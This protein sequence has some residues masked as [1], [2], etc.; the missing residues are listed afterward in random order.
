MIKYVEKYNTTVYYMLGILCFGLFTLQR[1]SVFSF[2]IGQAVPLLLL[3]VVISIGCFFKEWTGFWYG[4]LCGIAVDTV[5]SGT[6]VFNTLALMLIGLA[7]GL[8]FHYIL[9]RNIKAFAI[10]GTALTFLYYIMRWVFLVYLRKDPSAGIIL[11]EY[12][13]PSAIYTSVFGIPFFYFI[14]KIAKKYLLQK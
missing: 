12:I 9:N 10:F 11:M 6:F 1:I 8:V 3:P 2:K 13:I 7:S 5:A 4:L 14:R